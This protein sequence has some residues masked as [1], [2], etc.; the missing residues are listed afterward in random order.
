MNLDKERVARCFRQALSTYDRH[1]TVQREVGIR[2]L[3]LAE[4]IPSISFERVLEI[5]C[6]T[7]LLTRM[8]CQRQRVKTLF[9]NDLVPEFLEQIRIAL[10]D[11]PGP[12]LHPWFGD[13]E[14]IPLPEDLSLVLSSSTFQWLPDL[15]LVLTRLSQVLRPGG[16]L[17]FSCFG[18]GTLREVTELTGVGLDYRS[19]EQIKAMLVRNFMVEFMTTEQDRI[20]LATPRDVLHHLRHSGVGGIR[21]FRWTRSGLKEFEREYRNRFGLAGRDNGEAGGVPLTYTSIYGLARK[22]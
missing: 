3:E 14:Q 15:P 21:D 4:L 8:L 13:I 18:P 12:T 11:E 2:L 22:K 5:G 10:D 19:A 9:L 7:G 16:Y 17:V 20:V 6:C 1:A